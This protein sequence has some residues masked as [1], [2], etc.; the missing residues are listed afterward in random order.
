MLTEKIWEDFSGKLLSFIKNGV[1]DQTIAEDILQEIFIKI[2]LKSDS[3]QEKKALTAWLYQITRN[4]IIDYYRKKKIPEN[5]YALE[6]QQEEKVIQQDFTKCMSSFISQLPEKDKN[7]LEAVTFGNI[8]QKEYAQ[9][10]GLSYSATKSRVQRARSKLKDLF[11]ACCEI[12]ADKY[13]NI[14]KATEKDCN[15]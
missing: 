14:I 11:V 1:N 8:N 3:L 6:M 9:E 12:E 15:C 5:D 4:T 7:I 2:H 13:G 10:M